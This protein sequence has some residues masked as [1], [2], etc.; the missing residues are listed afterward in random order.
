MVEGKYIMPQLTKMYVTFFFPY[1]PYRIVDD[2][3]GAFVLGAT[4]GSVFHSIQG[5]RNAVSNTL[6]GNSS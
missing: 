1:S 3:G 2:C 4:G 6:I 5:F